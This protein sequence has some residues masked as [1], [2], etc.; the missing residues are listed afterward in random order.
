MATNM[1][2]EKIAS[3]VETGAKQLAEK[4]ETVKG[5]IQHRVQAFGEE[6][7]PMAKRVYARA[8]GMADDAVAWM[9]ENP[10]KSVAIGAGLGWFAGLLV[11][12]AFSS[13]K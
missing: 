11:M 9:K 3:K 4:A 8:E 7:T 5:N 12:R 6:V 10:I 1:Q 2:P 13:K